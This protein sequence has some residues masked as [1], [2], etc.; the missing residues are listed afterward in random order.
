LDAAACDPRC[1]AASLYFGAP[2]RL[3][4]E[5]YQPTARQEEAYLAPD[6]ES[7]PLEPADRDPQL[8][9]SRAVGD[10]REYS[11]PRI[12][13]KDRIGGDFNGDGILD[14]ATIGSVVEVGKAQILLG[15]GDGSFRAGPVYSFGF[16]PFYGATASLRRNGVLDLIV[17]DLGKDDIYVLLGNGDGTF[18][19]NSR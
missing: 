8:A 10:S 17:S 1:P 4:C 7:S 13:A 16:E 15:N 9:L 14:A 12:W 3:Y 5:A 6:Y 2:T 19:L 11:H 18:Q